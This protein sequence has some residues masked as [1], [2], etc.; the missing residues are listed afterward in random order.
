MQINPVSVGQR[1]ITYAC[2]AMSYM[3]K[4]INNLK[5]G[6]KNCQTNRN[7]WLY[8]LWAKSVADRTP[9]FEDGDW[10]N[11][12]NNDFNVYGFG[13]CVSHDF[14]RQVFEKADCY[15]DQCGCPPQDETIVYPPVDP[16]AITPAYTV[17]SAVDTGSQASIQAGPPNVGDS[18]FVVTNNAPGISWV[19]NTVVTWG[20]SGWVTVTPANGEVVNASGTYWVTYNGITPGLLWP[21]VTFTWV[22][23]PGGQYEI[24]SDAPQIAGFSGR[25]VQVQIFGPGGWIPVPGLQPFI[26]EVDIATPLLLD[27]QGLIF[28]EVSATYILGDCSWPGPVGTIEPP[29]CTFP[30]DHSCSSHSTQSHS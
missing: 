14:A 3:D 26:P 25:Q 17:I 29:E 19:V 28:T 2:C 30:R 15:C 20:G 10:N 24:Q 9:F 1:R 7:L 22:G 11:D 6:D 13:Q 18:Y 23:L 5:F 8:M 27:A 12:F 21:G 4:Y 16:C